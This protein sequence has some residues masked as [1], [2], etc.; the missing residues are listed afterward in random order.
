M[1]REKNIT[2]WLYT[3]TKHRKGELE[4]YVRS[5]ERKES[6]KRRKKLEPDYYH[7]R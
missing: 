5:Q 6:I 3:E 4:K 7:M 2:K 1:S